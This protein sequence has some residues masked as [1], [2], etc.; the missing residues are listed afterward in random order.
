MK[1]LVNILSKLTLTLGFGSLLLLISMGFQ[2][3]PQVQTIDEL[4]DYHVEKRIR[5]YYEGS[6]KRCTKE[7]LEEADRLVDSILIARA[8]NLINPMDTI[9]RPIIPDKPEMPEIPV[10][11][12]SM[13]IAPILEERDLFAD[14]M[15]FPVNK[16][17]TLLHKD[18]LGIGPTIEMPTLKKASN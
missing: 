11:N 18:S 2:E 1:R 5:K 9:N 13:P 8:R 15:K 16:K 14:S 6:I 4:I 7:V 12:D 10:I 3:Q 17:D